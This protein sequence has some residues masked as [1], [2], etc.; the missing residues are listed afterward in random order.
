MLDLAETMRELLDRPIARVP[1]LRGYTVV[2]MFYEASTR[3]PAPFEL[4]GKVLCCDRSSGRSSGGK[5]K[6]NGGV[7]EST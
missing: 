3:T 4:A 5:T 6:F 7:S 2:N 1:A